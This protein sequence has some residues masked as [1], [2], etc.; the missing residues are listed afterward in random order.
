MSD[1]ERQDW[2]TMKRVLERQLKIIDQQILEFAHD[3]DDDLFDFL[4]K[5]A[6][7]HRDAIIE[8]KSILTKPGND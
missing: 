4:I 6:I 2:L 3:G 8:I 7:K 5:K 1:D